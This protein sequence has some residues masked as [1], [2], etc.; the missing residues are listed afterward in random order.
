MK[1]LRRSGALLHISS[2]PG[3]FGS[4]DFGREAHDFAARLHSLGFSLWQT[5]PMTPV[6]GVFGNSPY[7]GSSAFAG[8][9]I[10]VSPDLLA[11]EGL[12]TEEEI[13]AERRP[14]QAAADFRHARECR[15]KLLKMARRRMQG[16]EGY[17]ALAE[18]FEKFRINESQWLRGFCLFETLKERFGGKCWAEWPRQFAQREDAALLKFEAENPD[19]VADCAFG[20]FMFFRQLEALSRRCSELGIEM[21]GDIPIYVAWDSAD[22]WEHHEYFDLDANGRPEDAAGVPPDYFSPTGQRWGNPLYNWERMRQ[23]GF[24]WW[25]ARLSHWLRYCGTMRIDHFRG[26]CAYWAVPAD[27][28]TAVN[29]EWRP[30]LGREMLESF[31]SIDMKGAAELP[32]A[33]EDLGIITDDVRALMKD[34]GLPG[35]KV[36]MFAFGGDMGSDPYAPHNIKEDSIVYTGTHDND[37]AAGWWRSGSSVHERMQ[38]RLYTGCEINEENAAAALIRLA[39]SSQASLAVLPVQDI[40]SLGGECR[41]NVPSKTE[42][43]WVWRLTPEQAAEL[44]PAYPGFAGQMKKLNDIYGRTPK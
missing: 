3:P 39:L 38:A 36:L 12:L 40:L 7:S 37:T 43:N 5:L 27:E 8:N 22:V 23:S 6:C 26:L 33:A 2:L 20:Q 25:R 30:A 1:R 15:K 34:M 24:S 31:R 18:Q 35:M 42:G 21:M 29:G 32:L 44:T 16:S 19:A 28:A 13:S 10:F 41:M 4:G 11:E 14:S 9:I 17:A